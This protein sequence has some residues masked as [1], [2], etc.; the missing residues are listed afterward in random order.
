MAGDQDIRLL[1]Q[2]ATAIPGN[3]FVIKV[4]IELPD[5]SRLKPGKVDNGI[6]A[7]G[8][9]DLFLFV[10]PEK[11]TV[12]F[13]VSWCVQNP[14]IG[15]DVIPISQWN[16]LFP[17]RTIKLHQGRIEGVP[18]GS[19]KQFQA[20]GMILMKM[21]DEDLGD[22]L[23]A[24]PV[25][26]QEALQ[27]RPVLGRVFRG[28]IPLPF[29]ARIHQ[30]DLIALPDNHYRRAPSY[31]QLVLQSHLDRRGGISRINRTSPSLNYFNI[32]IPHFFATRTLEFQ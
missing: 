6:S 24:N 27:H 16:E 29:I 25:P 9:F 21:G 32:K 8:H 23:W 13:G 30:K 28:N 26:I 2:P 7:Y 15:Q 12:P 11:G 20:A 31:T 18:V 22:L 14:R 4:S 3:L 17:N 19:F 10:G 5:M 1:N